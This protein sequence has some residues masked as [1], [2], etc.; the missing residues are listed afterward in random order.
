MTCTVPVWVTPSLTTPLS[1]LPPCGWCQ[2]F[3][4][5]GQRL[6]PTEITCSSMV[7]TLS[8]LLPFPLV[9]FTTT[10][11]SRRVFGDIRPVSISQIHLHACKLQ[12]KAKYYWS[13]LQHHHKL[14]TTSSTDQHFVMWNPI[15]F[16]QPL[17]VMMCPNLHLESTCYTNLVIMQ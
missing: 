13:N 10:P 9:I 6:D 8:L 7:W 15:H 17:N 4:A 16:F 1:S 3:S 5:S 12:L 14:W 2:S 11:T